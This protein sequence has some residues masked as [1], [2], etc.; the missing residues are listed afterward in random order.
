MRVSG[1]STRVEDGRCIAFANATWE[2][3]DRPAREMTIET[4]ARFAND[5]AA[6]PHAFLLGAIFP[7]MRH[8]EKRIEIEGPLCPRL[9]DGLVAAMHQLAAWYG[10]EGH[11]EVEIEATRGFVA[12]VPRAGARAASLMSGGIDS[13][14][15]LRTNR[16][17]Y[18]PDHPAFVHDCLYVHGVDVGG[19]ESL[20]QNRES[21]RVAIDAL[22]AFAGRVDAELIPVYT[23]FR[24]LDDSDHL[25][26]YESH[27]AVLSAMA[28]AFPGRIGRLSIP[29]S[30]T[31]EELEPWGS[32]PLLD[33]LYG[34]ASLEVMHDGLRY[35][36]F[37]KVGIVADWPPALAALR[38]CFD[39]FRPGLNCGRCEKCLR[40]MTSL[41]VLGK[42]AAC[43]TYEVDDVPIDAIRSLHP[44]P[45][46]VPHDDLEVALDWAY[47]SMSEASA[48]FWR[49]LVE[50]LRAAG[51]G[52]LADA[53]DQKIREVEARRVPGGLRGLARRIDRSVL[54]G[55]LERVADRI[56]GRA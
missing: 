31:M 40:T 16:L 1:L 24:H 12:P 51:R 49:Q 56:G 47:R 44:G 10:P 2:D 39:A 42:L 38:S 50:P 14:A 15:T 19:Y 43:P 48:F 36:R 17:A 35:A 54:G 6:A 5:L 53:V 21:A 22:S 3:C 11:G 27:G 28:H 8:G 7:A 13:L 20:P 29:S 23:N 26:S 25:F 45:P 33:P 55:T 52:E 9:R 4:D 30:Y 32:H 41:L 46:P 18:P 37:E 34:S